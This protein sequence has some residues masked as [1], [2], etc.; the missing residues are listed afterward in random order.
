VRIIAVSTLRDFWRAPGHEDAQRPLR[1]WIGVVRRA[2]WSKPTELKADFNTADILRDG[3]VVF[4]I[5]GN[6]YRL[7]AWI[8]YP[9]RVLYVR[10]VGTHRE[11]DRIDARTV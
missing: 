6:K 2:D 4:D 5:G 1:A 8:N 9:Y 11:Y 3:R 10:F 7:V